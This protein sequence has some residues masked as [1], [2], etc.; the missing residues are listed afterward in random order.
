MIRFDKAISITCYYCKSWQ[1]TDYIVSVSTFNTDFIISGI[2]PYGLRELVVLGYSKEV[3]DDG[4]PL[5]P[6]LHLLEPQ[7]DDYIDMYAD[8]LSLRGYVEYAANDYKLGKVINVI[9]II[10]I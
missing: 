3:D 4:K 6:H 2:A 9:S 1:L 7:A 8:N 10:I 5:R